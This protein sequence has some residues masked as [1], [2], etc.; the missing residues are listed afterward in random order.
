MNDRRVPSWRFVTA[1]AVL[2]VVALFVGLRLSDTGIT[3]AELQDKLVESCEST[4]SPLQAY[5]EGEIAA[6][7]ATDPSLFPDID[8]D[9]FAQLIDEKV[10]RL[11]ALVDTFD[12]AGCAAAY[13]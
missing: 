7:E 6:T 10:A 1:I 12:P 11:Q 8:P 13:Q 3:A 9:V 5:F 2:A 4:R